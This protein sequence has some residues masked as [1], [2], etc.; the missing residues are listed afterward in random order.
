ML[1]KERVEAMRAMEERVCR[2]SSSVVFV[3]RDTVVIV[4]HVLLGGNVWLR[5]IFLVS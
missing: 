1:Q 2:P 5:L 4:S 3:T